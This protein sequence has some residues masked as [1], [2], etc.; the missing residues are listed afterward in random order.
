MVQSLGKAV[1][2]FQLSDGIGAFCSTYNEKAWKNGKIADSL[3]TIAAQNNIREME[4]KQTRS[5]K[6]K[7]DL[8]TSNKLL[9]MQLS[10]QAKVNSQQ[11]KAIDK[12]NSQNKKILAYIAKNKDKYALRDIVDLQKPMIQSKDL[13]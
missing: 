8:I 2:F 9:S 1:G 11:I 6:W 3:F 12:I 13:H 7:N 10:T 5:E 4:T